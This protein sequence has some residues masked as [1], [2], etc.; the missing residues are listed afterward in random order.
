LKREVSL[1]P[2]VLSA[3]P[4]TTEEIQT[5]RTNVRRLYTL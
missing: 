1:H 4:F 3:K 5:G 2:S